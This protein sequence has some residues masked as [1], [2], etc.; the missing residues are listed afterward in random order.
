MS[1]GQVESRDDP[2]PETGLSTQFYRLRSFQNLPIRETIRL[3][4]VEM[5]RLMSDSSAGTFP[6]IYNEALEILAEYN[7]SLEARFE[8]MVRTQERKYWANVVGLFGVF[9]SVL[10]LVIVGLPKITTDPT[11]PFWSVFWLNVAQILPVALVLAVFV[12]VARWVVR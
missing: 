5:P 4:D 9:V 1:D 3:G 12:L 10:A 8:R 7:R 6:E 11:L 2:R